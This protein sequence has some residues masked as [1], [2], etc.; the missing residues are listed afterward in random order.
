MKKYYQVVI[1]GIVLSLLLVGCVAV[2]DTIGTRPTV[3][4]PFILPASLPSTQADTIPN[5]GGMDAQFPGLPN[6]LGGAGH[7]LLVEEEKDEVGRSCYLYE[8]G[9]V[10]VSYWV[11]GSGVFVEHGVGF[12]LFVDGMPQAYRTSEDGEYSYMHCFKKEDYS[13][14]GLGDMRLDVNFM[15]EPISG[16]KGD[17]IECHIVRLY[18]P[19]YSMEALGDRGVRPYTLVLG[20]ASRSFVLK[21]MADPPENEP[22]PVQDRLYDLEI[23]MVDTTHEEI[24]GWSNDDML[25]NIRTKCYVNGL[26]PSSNT[27]LWDVAKD[28]VITVQF[29]VYGSPLVHYGLVWFMDNRPVS[30]E[31]EDIITFGVEGGK[32]TVVTAKLD[33]SDF[34][35]ES[36]LYCVLVPRNRREFGSAEGLMFTSQAL[37]YFFLVDDP[38]PNW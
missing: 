23:N 2:P 13:S 30:V 16:K 26:D 29:E 9:E 38:K 37:S 11:E 15:F 28:D 20:S 21:Y 18:Y 1:W 3:E 36:H 19:D 17:Y 22:L 6:P 25:K 10:C 7:G 4:D 5:S 32:K 34:D 12:L 27:I 31:K 33:I 35:G 24:N 8:G 14:L